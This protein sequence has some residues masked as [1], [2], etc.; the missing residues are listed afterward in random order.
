MMA[1]AICNGSIRPGMEVRAKS[2]LHAG[3]IADIDFA[4]DRAFIGGVYYHSIAA[5][6]GS[7]HASF[8]RPSVKW[9]RG[10]D[11][12]YSSFA[13]NVL[14]WDERGALL[15]ESAIELVPRNQILGEVPASGAPALATSGW[16][17][18]GGATGFAALSAEQNV[19][20]ITTQPQVINGG[21]AAGYQ[22]WKTSSGLAYAAGDYTLSIA[23]RRAPGKSA[24]DLYWYSP[25]GNAGAHL[26]APSA[27]LNDDWQI[28]ELTQTATGSGSAACQIIKTSVF[29]TNFGVEFTLP[30]LR[31]GAASSPILTVGAGGSRAADQANLMLEDGSYSTRYLLANG[32]E[33]TRGETVSGG[34]GFTLPL[35]LPHNILERVTFF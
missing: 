32:S 11:G 28:F 31:A 20:G 6:M 30:M 2:W 13:D 15:E 16:G 23:A 4:N 27:A 14:A 26:L 9:L 18:V 33:I 22:G 34:F 25:V 35:D 12:D 19:L 3:A 7:A 5:L 8:S 29:D 17:Q 1:T 21:D 24:F 10:A